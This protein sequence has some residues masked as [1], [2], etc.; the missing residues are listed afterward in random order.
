VTE[1]RLLP[2]TGSLF[3][4]LLDVAIQA[5]IFLPAES[6][7]HATSIQRQ[8]SSKSRWPGMMKGREYTTEYVVGV[9][10][11]GD[12]HHLVRIERPT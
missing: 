10:M 7:E 12:V 5:S 6:R 1:R 8:C 2:N 11:T 4:K 9:S 3:Y